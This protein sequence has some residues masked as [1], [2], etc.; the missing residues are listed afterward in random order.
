M[1]ILQYKATIILMRIVYH[2]EQRDFGSIVRL[3]VGHYTQQE[4]GA[5]VRFALILLRL[6]RQQLDMETDLEM[7][8]DIL[9][10]LEMISTIVQTPFYEF[11]M[12]DLLVVLSTLFEYNVT[13]VSS[14]HSIVS[15]SRGLY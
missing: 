4:D 13:S 10:V 8:G 3:N 14:F 12:K 6:Y 9:Y 11:G 5:T 1:L 15:L 2:E 7:V